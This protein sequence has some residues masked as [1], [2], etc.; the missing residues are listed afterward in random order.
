MSFA[1]TT[2]L[3]LVCFVIRGLGA[4]KQGEQLSLL[5]RSQSAEVQVRVLRVEMDAVN[6]KMKSQETICPMVEIKRSRQFLHF[7]AFFVADLSGRSQVPAKTQ[8]HPR[9]SEAVRTSIYN[10]CDRVSMQTGLWV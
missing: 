7:L 2:W 8:S 4:L 10:G 9:A 6:L 3:T 5:Y 1:L